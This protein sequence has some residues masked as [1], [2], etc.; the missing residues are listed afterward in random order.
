MLLRWVAAISACSWLP[1]THFWIYWFCPSRQF[2]SEQ[3]S[4]KLQWAWISSSCS[5]WERIPAFGDA[6]WGDEERCS[7][8]WVQFLQVS[9]SF[10]RRTKGSWKR[11]CSWLLFWG[12]T[13]WKLIVTDPSYLPNVQ[14]YRFCSLISGRERSIS[15]H[16]RFTATVWYARDPPHKTPTAALTRATTLRTVA[17]GNF[18]RPPEEWALSC[19]L[20]G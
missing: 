6:F 16:N 18:D 11:Y 9:L 2:F 20:A 17:S 19:L 7:C 10:R 15:C 4:L 5:V 3:G 1:M 12:H 13:C 8:G 14:S